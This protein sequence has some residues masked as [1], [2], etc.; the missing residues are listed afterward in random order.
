MFFFFLIRISFF[1]ERL[2]NT[3]EPIPSIVFV[4]FVNQYELSPIGQVIVRRDRFV[5]WFHSSC[6]S[7]EHTP[8]V[9][10]GCRI[11]RAK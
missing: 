6:R 11:R 10:A 9:V 3:V 1:H 2:S 8:R 4:D 5:Q 7:D